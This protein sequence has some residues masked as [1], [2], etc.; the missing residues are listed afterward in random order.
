MKKL[1]ENYNGPISISYYI[2]KYTDYQKIT[3]LWYETKKMRR[4]VNI[5]LISNMINKDIYLNDRVPVNVMKNVAVE[6]A[7]TKYV[8]VLDN[9]DYVKVGNGVEYYLRRMGKGE[10]LRVSGRGVYYIFNRNEI[11]KYFEENINCNDLKG[12]FLFNYEKRI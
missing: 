12:N 2:E 6:N 5:H 11:P 3:Q 7:K 10:I 1:I 8:L 9:N 4:N